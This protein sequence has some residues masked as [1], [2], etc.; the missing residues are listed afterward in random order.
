VTAAPSNFYPDL[1]FWLLY[2]GEVLTPVFGQPPT[3]SDSKRQLIAQRAVATCDAVD[4]LVDGQITNPRACPFDIDAMGP[5]GDG[6]L[7][8]D[9]VAAAKK[10]YAGTVSE[11]GVVRYAGAMPGSEA[12]WNPAFADNGGYGPFIGHYVYGVTSPPF[13]WRRDLNYADIYDDVKAALS[14]VTAAPTPDLTAFVNNGGKLIQTHGWGDPIVPPDGS[15]AYHRAVA[16]FERWKS[17]P[18]GVVDRAIERLTPQQVASAANMMRARVQSYH[19][20]FLLPAVAHCGGSTGPD[21][22]GGGMTEP[23][24]AYRDADHHV[25]NAVMRWVE[26]GVAPEKIVATKIV[27]GAP[28]RSRPLCVWPAEA[29]YK[30]Q[31][32][33]DDASSFECKARRERAED[34]SARDIMLIQNSLRQRDLMLPNR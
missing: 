32:N 19:R 17:L 16:L 2:S 25:V 34:V 26:N 15:I 18:D 10:M 8:A 12:S 30:G 22:I 11:A 29:A 1:L 5:S 33:I 27:G 4:G 21:A 3:L 9:E 28:V 20:L 14:P 24:A 23:P 7:T 13:D 6:S 31:G